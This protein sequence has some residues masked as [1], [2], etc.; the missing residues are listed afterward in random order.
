MMRPML[1]LRITRAALTD[2]SSARSWYAERDPSVAAGF[3]AAIEAL[4]ERVCRLPGLGS[5]WPGIPGLRRA[6][7]PGYPYWLVYEEGATALTVVAVA[8]QKRRPLYWL[9]P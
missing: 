2:W 6:M 5:P 3:S 8:H 9:E 1:E 7:V 4:A